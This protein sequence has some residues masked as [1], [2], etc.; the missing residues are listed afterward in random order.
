MWFCLALKH[1]LKNNQEQELGPI[2]FS[3][4]FCAKLCS[5]GLARQSR[6]SQAF[7]QFI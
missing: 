7:K 2:K 4:L 5:Q 1:S 6:M 3:K